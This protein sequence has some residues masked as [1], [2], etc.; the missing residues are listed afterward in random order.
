MNLKLWMILAVLAALVLYAPALVTA[1]LG[2]LGTV[3]VTAAANPT[4]LGFALGVAAAPR[5]LRSTR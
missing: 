1:L 4:V 3:A 5:I 2:A